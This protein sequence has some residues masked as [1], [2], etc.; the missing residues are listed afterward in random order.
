MDK[1]WIERIEQHSDSLSKTESVLLGF[2]NRNPEQASVLSQKEFASLAGVSKPVVIN[3]FRKLGYSSFR[4]FQDGIKQFFSTH[5]DSYSASRKMQNRVNSISD[6]ISE[7]VKVDVRSLE[8][9]NETVPPEVLEG[10][11]AQA[12][13]S[14]RVWVVG[15]GTGSYPAHYLA[16]RLRRYR[17][18]GIELQQDR[19]HQM[20][21]LFPMDAEDMIILF[22][23][24][25]K[26]SWMWPILELSQKRGAFSFVIAGTI[27]PRYV[28]DSNL[29]V[30]VPRGELQFKNS[31]AVPMSFANM[32]LLSIEISRGALAEEDLRIL[33][34]SRE[35]WENKRRG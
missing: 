23:Y 26:D 1:D 20:D 3:L 2:V 10:F 29:F 8:R 27:R 14:K 28:A 34:D 30:H 13:S 11:A 22:Q 19:S 24:S 17:I 21:E 4:D 12:V 9:L 18:T 16:Q 33:E 15:E 7:A 35:A 6:L 5:I 32:L 31:M 25:D